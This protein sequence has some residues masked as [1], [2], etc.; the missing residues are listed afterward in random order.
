MPCALH[1]FGLAPNG[2]LLEVGVKAGECLAHFE[3]MEE[4]LSSSREVKLQLDVAESPPFQ[5]P[6][7]HPK[8]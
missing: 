1:C 2:A 8:T 6:Q 7:K 3:G 5:D 4:A